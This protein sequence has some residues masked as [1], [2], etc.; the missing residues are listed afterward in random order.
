MGAFMK[1]RQKEILD[2]ITG[3]S[4]KLPEGL[5]FPSKLKSPLASLE[6]YQKA[7]RATFFEVLGANFESVWKLMGDDDFLKLC[8]SFRE[9]H[10]SKSYNVDDLGLEFPEF[11]VNSKW[12]QEIP[13]LAD[14][15]SLD[16]AVFLQFRRAQVEH[17]SSKISPQSKDLDLRTQQN[18]FIWL[19]SGFNIFQLWS[20]LSDDKGFEEIKSLDQGVLVYKANNL[21]KVMPFNESEMYLVKALLDGL[22][23]SEAV[24]LCVEVELDLSHLQETLHKLQGIPGLY[25]VEV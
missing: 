4:Q 15:A 10:L 23:L 3:R 17:K 5:V 9:K 24:G 1:L 18:A 14:L 11:I 8:D 19:E 13:Y 22:K 7:Y 6:I 12:H 21:L 16:R 25:L 20:D 2:F